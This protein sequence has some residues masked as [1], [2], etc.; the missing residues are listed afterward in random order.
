MISSIS[1][2]NCFIFKNSIYNQKKNL[3]MKKDKNINNDKLMI[4]LIN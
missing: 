4:N 1:L 2:V 3:V